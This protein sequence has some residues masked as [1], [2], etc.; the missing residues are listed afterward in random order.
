LNGVYHGAAAKAEAPSAAVSNAGV[1]VKEK[2]RE[3]R[4]KHART[5]VNFKACVRRPGL[6]DHVV[7]CEDMPGGGLRFKS[8]RK[9]FEKMLIDLAVP[10]A[11]GDQAIFVPAQ[12][13]F[14][15]ELPEQNT[16]RCGVRYLRSSAR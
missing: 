6:A 3:N 5:R 9:Y 10:Y 2:D 14:V 1:A 12:I 11:P 15:Q 8:N 7:T 4:Q 13:V 16:Y